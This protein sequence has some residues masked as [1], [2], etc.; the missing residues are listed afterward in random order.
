MAK[1]SDLILRTSEVTG[2]PVA[3]VREVSRRL[4]EA[5]LIQT[6][7]GGRYGGADM[8]PRD[9]ASLLT[10]LLIAR[11]SSVSLSNIVPLTRSH[12]RDLRSYF[13]NSDRLLLGHWDR[14]LALAQ[15]C[16]LPRGHTFGD[17]F[18]AL[19]ASIP[20]GDLKRAIADW[21][22]NRPRGVAPFFKFVVSVNGPRPHPEA[23][24]EFEAPAFDSL[25]LYYLRPRDVRSEKLILLDAPRK[26]ADLPD[27]REFDL[28]VQ[29]RV[30][31]M[32][33]SSIG[34]LLSKPE[35]KDA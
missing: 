35:A 26:W 9:A 33:L 28:T 14:K 19:I 7:R 2:I 29:A 25:E 12:L 4:R 16:S 27:E 30:T 1:L 11:A 6:G 13:P 22:A 34:R 21:A 5:D 15:L 8:T 20:N 3:T 23:M 10:A 32:T 17:A 18:S 24:I 31:E